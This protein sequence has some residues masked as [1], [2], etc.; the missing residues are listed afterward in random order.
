MYL[1]QSNCN[2]SVSIRYTCIFSDSQICVK[3]Q[4]LNSYSVV[5]LYLDNETASD[6]KLRFQFQFSNHTPVNRTAKQNVNS[7]FFYLSQFAVRMKIH[8]AS[9]ASS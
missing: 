7:N 6:F 4:K 5:L 8:D 3:K 9:G 1:L 2:F